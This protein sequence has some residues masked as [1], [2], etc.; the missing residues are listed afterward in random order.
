MYSCFNGAVRLYWP[1][2]NPSEA[3]YSPVYIPERVAQLGRQLVEIIFKQLAAISA[4]RFLPGP[5]AVDALDF[6]QEE[7]RLEAERMRILARD[8]NDYSQL[9]DLSDKENVRLRES[10][11]RFQKRT[12]IFERV[13]NSPR[14][15]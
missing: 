15:T 12:K 2:F 14:T 11:Q 4:F 8:S 3:P 10:V 6:L 13:Y 7:K 9:L 5:V 1:D